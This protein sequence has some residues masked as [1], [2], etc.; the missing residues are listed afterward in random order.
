[1]TMTTD[2]KFA[3]IN[4]LADANLCMRKP[5][6]WYVSQSVEIKD[7]GMLI[8][9]Y[10]NGSTPEDAIEDHWKILTGISHPKHLI[11]NAGTERRKAARW[12][13]FMWDHIQ[14]SP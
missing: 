2:E 6:D 14:E 7:G 9:E 4:A 13:G 12:N 10:G 5:G 1:M 8:G 3:A 11:A